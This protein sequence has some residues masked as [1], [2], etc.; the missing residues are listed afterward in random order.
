M[1]ASHTFASAP[2]RVAW[3]GPPAVPVSVKSAKTTPRRY[4]IATLLST[5]A[6]WDER[7][8]FRWDIERMLRDE[9]Y[10]IRDIGLTRW[11]VEAEIAKPFW[12]A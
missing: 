12:Q 4:R 5:F 10:L 9:P 11:E 2:Y 8:R 1:N 7:T 6:T 3:P